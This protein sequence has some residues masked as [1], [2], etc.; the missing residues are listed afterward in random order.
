MK[1]TDLLEEMKQIPGYGNP[2]YEQIFFHRR[3]HALISSRRDEIAGSIKEFE[4]PLADA[5][6]TIDKL[7]ASAAER[8]GHGASKLFG[9]NEALKKSAQSGFAEGYCAKVG[10]LDYQ[11][12]SYLR[13]LRDNAARVEQTR[14]AASGKENQ[15]AKETLMGMA[16]AWDMEMIGYTRILE[17]LLALRGI[18]KV[19]AIAGLALQGQKLKFLLDNFEMI[20]KA[21][22]PFSKLPV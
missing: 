10:Y 2:G 13:K 5:F 9:G 22:T 18:V 12:R 4:P 7:V 6:D 20:D 11:I 14:D 15:S 8:V 21:E 3:V 17:Q 1:A 16:N 19:Y